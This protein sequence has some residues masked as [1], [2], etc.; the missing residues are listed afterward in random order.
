M[1]LHVQSCKLVHVCGI[2]CHVCISSKS[3]Y[4]FLYFTVQY[5]LEYSSTVALFQAQDV[6]K[7]HK[8][9]GDAAGTAKKLQ[10]ITVK[11]KVKIIEGVE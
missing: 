11:T 6:Q 8:S 2:T 7:K 4:T 3:S 9:S 1:H 5:Y 10:A